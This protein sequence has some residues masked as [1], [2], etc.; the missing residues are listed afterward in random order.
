MSGDHLWKTYPMGPIMAC[1]ELKTMLAERPTYERELQEAAERSKNY[2]RKILPWEKVDE[3]FED[4]NARQ[5]RR[6]RHDIILVASLIEKMPNLG[7]LCRTCEIFNVSTLV[8]PSIKV[9]D[10]RL[11]RETSNRTR[12]S[13]ACR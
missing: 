11:R 7:G 4:M 9:I 2:Q 1:R 8:V 13:R 12:C 5:A 3:S 10:V 6:K